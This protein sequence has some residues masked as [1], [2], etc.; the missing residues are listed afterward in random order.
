MQLVKDFYAGV[1]LASLLAVASCD[2]GSEAPSATDSAAQ[3]SVTTSLPEARSP[4]AAEYA[5]AESREEGSGRAEGRGRGG[6][7]PRDQPIPVHSDGKPLWSA[8]SRNTAQENA[9]RLFERNG[10]A[11]GAKTVDQYV[12]MA[13]DFIAEP[14]KGAM[15]LTRN[16]GDRLLYDPKSNT[17]AVATREGAPRTMFKPDDGMAYWREQEQRAA[18]RSNGDRA[19]S[20][21]D[22]G[23]GRG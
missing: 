13:H 23:G 9:Q 2:R 21:G 3:A 19:G 15:T 12:D 1:V 5:E 11:F 22:S 7:D 6:D 8:N 18:R 14:P 4:D 16:N 17:F 20:N 10:Q